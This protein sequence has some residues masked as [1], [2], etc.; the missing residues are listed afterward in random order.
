MTINKA[1]TSATETETVFHAGLSQ[2]ENKALIRNNNTELVNPEAHRKF[3]MKAKIWYNNEK[4]MISFE[5]Q[6]KY[7]YL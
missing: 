4:R 1:P 2:S 7:H 5:D 3:N 6:K